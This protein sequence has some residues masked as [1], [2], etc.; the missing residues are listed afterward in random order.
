[1]WIAIASISGALAV[2]AGALVAALAPWLAGVP[3]RVG[4]A[5][6]RASLLTEAVRG[7]PAKQRHQTDF[8]LDLL[9]HLGLKAD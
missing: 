9:R 3:H 4:H 6:Q 2:M 1:M 5:G 8:Y 7:L